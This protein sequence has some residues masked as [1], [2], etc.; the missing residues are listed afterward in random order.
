MT[1]T[2]TARSSRRKPA[3]TE[4]GEGGDTVGAR[5][6]AGAAGCARGIGV[7]RCCAGCGLGGVAGAA[8]GRAL[9]RWG[10]SR[11]EAG[12][13]RADLVIGQQVTVSRAVFNGDNVYKAG[14]RVPERACLDNGTACPD[15]VWFGGVLVSS[16]AV[17]LLLLT[18]RG[19]R[20]RL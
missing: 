2:E 17:N 15:Y 5:A 12:S 16:D 1:C 20:R 14:V 4:N 18:R 7:M 10:F 19:T 8:R 9:Q 3:G 11:I 6:F 13:A